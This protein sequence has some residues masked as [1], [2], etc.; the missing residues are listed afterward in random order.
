MARGRRAGSRR[1]RPQ[2]V[3]SAIRPMATPRRWWPGCD[4]VCPSRAPATSSPRRRPAPTRRSAGRRTGWCA[5]RPRPP[6]RDKRD[7]RDGRPDHPSPR[8]AAAA[9]QK[10]RVGAGEDRQRGEV[11][12]VHGGRPLLADGNR[13]KPESAETSSSLRPPARSGSAWRVAASTAP[14]NRPAIEVPRTAT[15]VEVTVHGVGTGVAPQNVITAIATTIGP[16]GRSAPAA[17]VTLAAGFPHLPGRQPC[18]IR[19]HQLASRRRRWSQRWRCIYTRRRWPPGPERSPRCSHR[20]T[21]AQRRPARDGAA[22][23]SVG[24]PRAD[25]RTASARASSSPSNGSSWNDVATVGRGGA[26]RLRDHAP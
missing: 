16:T 8:R 13:T 1:P 11:V 3:R 26:A 20:G 21:T 12:R 2:L 18:R 5:R 24:A 15:V 10:R 19:S 4:S 22:R 14:P 6:E 9:R 23:S 17:A 7:L 25:V